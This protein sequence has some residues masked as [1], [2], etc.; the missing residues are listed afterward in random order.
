MGVAAGDY[1]SC[2]LSE[3]GE[4]WTWGRPHCSLLGRHEEPHE[5]GA[6]AVPNLEPHPAPGDLPG[7]M[8]GVQLPRPIAGG[9][10]VQAVASNPK[11]KPKPQPKPQPKPN[12]KPN[13]K[14]EQAVACGA[15]HCLLLSGG[16][17]LSWG[18]GEI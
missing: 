17:L 1:V 15:S 12:P 4:C 7:P 5:P 9:L 14:P 6:D 18:R 2:A 8:H 13:P 16:R 10:R 3:A 11:P